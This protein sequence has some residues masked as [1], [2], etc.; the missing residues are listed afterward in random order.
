MSKKEGKIGDLRIGAFKD[1]PNVNSEVS[2][3]K[4]PEWQQL[5][6]EEKKSGKKMTKRPGRTRPPRVRNDI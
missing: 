3:V 5:P 1:W 4:A 6:Q 2:L